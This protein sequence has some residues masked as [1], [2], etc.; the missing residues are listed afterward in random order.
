VL[1]DW[2]VGRTQYGTVRSASHSSHAS[3][4]AVGLAE[5][6]PVLLL[7]SATKLSTTN[8]VYTSIFAPRQKTY[9]MSSSV[10]SWGMANQPFVSLWLK[11][12]GLISRMTAPARDTEDIRV[13]VTQYLC[14]VDIDQV[15]YCDE[16]D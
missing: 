4:P 8:L 2:V 7:E 13:V 10:L 15:N 1:V 6:Q 5:L 14:K 11:S 16:L 3:K 12:E 9:T